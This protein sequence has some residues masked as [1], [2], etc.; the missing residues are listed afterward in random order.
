[1]EEIEQDEQFAK[2]KKQIRTPKTAKGRRLQKKKNPQLE[3]GIRKTLFI[4]GQK[5]SEQVSNFMKDL[6]SLKK[7]NSLNF[8]RRHEI[9]PFE[10]IQQ[11]ENYCQKQDCAFFLFGSHNKK[12]PNN[13]VLGRIYDN[14]VLDMVEL[15]IN[16][17]QSQNEKL[18][19]VDIPAQCRPVLVFQ[20]PL[21]D[22]EPSFVRIKNLLNDFFVENIEVKEIDIIKGLKYTLVFT[23]DQQ[24][25]YM[26]TYLIES[27]QQND[28]GGN[29][30]LT[31]IGPSASLNIRRSQFAPEET[32]KKACKQPKI[33]T[34]KQ[35]K[36]VFKDSVGDKKVKVW[37]DRQNLDVLALK[38]RKKLKGISGNEKVIELNLKQDLRDLE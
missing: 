16:N 17:L 15:G 14:H 26:K 29:L 25:I 27:N 31:E 36:N 28:K 37:L 21:F 5:T 34:K 7:I 18:G 19:L 4:K 22:S 13:I 23:A 24:N 30:S 32:F 12:R 2:I 9:R 38:K 3:E 6:Y 11:I 1:M 10:E 35:D 8:S 20:G 33:K